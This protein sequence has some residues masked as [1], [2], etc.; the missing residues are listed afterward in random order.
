MAESCG[1]CIDG[2]YEG[3]CST[4]MGSGEGSYD[5]STCQACH[6]KGTQK[7]YCDCARGD[8]R[9]SEEIF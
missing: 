6:G 9:V 2:I 5:G 1:D 8:E 7:E 3:I 4:C